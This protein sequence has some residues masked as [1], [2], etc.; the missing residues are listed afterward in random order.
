MPEDRITPEENTDVDLRVSP[1]QAIAL[2]TQ[3][4]LDEGLDYPTGDLEAWLVLGECW[5]V[6][7]RTDPHDLASLRIGGTRFLVTPNG[8]VHRGSGSLPVPGVRWAHVPGTDIYPPRVRE[9]GR[10]MCGKA[11]YDHP[12]RAATLLDV[13]EADVL[14][15]RLDGI[16]ATY[17]SSLPT[18]TSVI[19]DRYN[20][21]Y[22]LAQPDTNP[23]DHV[24]D[25]R[26]GRRTY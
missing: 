20:P 6:A 24:L 15:R 25:F 7:P 21:T 10:P 1:H 22:L 4:C 2:V 16:D 19:L 13:P 12:A 5:E 17:Y 18:A 23:E 11:S 26:D 14:E 3:H 9:P 8:A